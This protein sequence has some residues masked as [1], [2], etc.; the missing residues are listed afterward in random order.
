[1]APRQPRS[2]PIWGIWGGFLGAGI[3]IG[4][5][6]ADKVGPFAFRLY[7]IAIT[8]LIVRYAWVFWRRELRWLAAGASVGACIFGS[9]AL[10]DG[11]DQANAAFDNGRWVW[12]AAGLVVAVGLFF[13]ENKYSQS[14]FALLR[15]DLAGATWWQR[16]TLSVRP[17]EPI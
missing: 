11:L 15:E 5:F 2:E 6:I 4:S 1:M 16:A 3:N 8:L 7:W 9:F 12:L 14:K 13:I 17:P 10:F